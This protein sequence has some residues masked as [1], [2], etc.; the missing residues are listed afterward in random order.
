MFRKRQYVLRKKTVYNQL[1][2]LT[3]EIMRATSSCYYIFY[4]Y[5]V[6]RHHDAARKQAGCAAFCN[7]VFLFSSVCSRPKKRS[8]YTKRMWLM[9]GKETDSPTEN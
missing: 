8:A 7:N 2:D 5:A 9:R 4:L 6:N 3:N 1:V